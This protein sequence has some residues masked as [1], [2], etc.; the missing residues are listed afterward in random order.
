M[1]SRNSQSFSSESE[2]ETK[3]L[4]EEINPKFFISCSHSAVQKVHKLTEHLVAN[5][6]RGKGNSIVLMNFLTAS[7]VSEK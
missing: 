2:Y 5:G 4:E 6:E 3:L 7:A 1:E